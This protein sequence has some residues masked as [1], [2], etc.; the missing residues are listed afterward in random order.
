M[1]EVML[2]LSLWTR[3]YFINQLHELTLLDGSREETDYVPCGAS[4]SSGLDLA[5][6]NDG[7]AHDFDV[8]HH[9]SPQGGPYVTVVSATCEKARSGGG[10]VVFATP[11][12]HNEAREYKDELFSVQASL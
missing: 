11:R 6:L 1:L 8:C 3:F 2:G 12:P 10:V 5:S 9:T 7:D 4:S